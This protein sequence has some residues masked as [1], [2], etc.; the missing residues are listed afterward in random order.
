[1]KKLMCILVS[2]LVLFSLGLSGC[3]DNKDDVAEVDGTRPVLTMGNYTITYA[4]YKALYDSYLPYMQANGLDPLGSVTLLESFQDWLIQSLADDIVVLYQAELNGFTLSEEQEQQLAEE[5]EKEINDLYTEYYS[6]AEEDYEND[7]S[8]SVADRFTAFINSV[9]KYYTGVE[10]SWDEYKEEYSAEKRRA[11][12]I[13]EYKELVTQ[14]FVPESSDITDW[15]DTEYDS[16]KTN[17]TASPG[18]YK[19]D[20]ESFELYYGLKDDIYP[21]T[22][23]PEGYSRMMHIVVS[24]EGE[25]SEEYYSK[26]DQMEQL[27]AEFGSL[28]FEDALNGTDANAERIAE[29]LAEYTAL[30]TET[31]TEF[32]TYSQSALEKINRAYAALEAGQPFAEVMLE[33]TEDELIIGSDDTNGCEAFQQKG[34]LISLVHDSSDDWS[35]GIKDEFRKL[36]LNEYSEVFVDGGSY[37][38]IYYAGDE[39]SGDIPMQDIYGIISEIIAP[40]I[41][42]AQWEE[43][44]EEWRND[45]ALVKDMDLIRSIGREDV[46]GDSDDA[47]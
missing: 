8:I 42:E 12:I 31:D 10:M 28:A 5:T 46:N 29:I 4:V 7:P 11:F 1:M 18:R 37:H 45:P 9:S 47:S 3:G 14:E 40:D 2:A 36:S 27:R 39:P 20:Q 43:L 30:K 35:T 34:Q 44:L 21:V 16:D 41:R 25:L 24:P 38:I 17:Y 15:Y 33:Y 19:A 6:M 32:E 13:Q 26:L 22:Y 23:V